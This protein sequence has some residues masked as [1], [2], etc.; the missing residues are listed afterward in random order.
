[1]SPVLALEKTTHKSTIQE[2][3][4]VELIKQIRLSDTF[5][6][7]CGWSDELLVENIVISLEKKALNSPNLNLDPLYQLI[8]KAFY[9]AIAYHI[10][11][12]TGHNT[13]THIHV[14]N[15]EFSSAVICC[16]SVLVLNS[17]IS[18]YK[19]LGFFSLPELIETAENT[20]REAVIKASYYLDF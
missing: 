3:F 15:K 1:M 7:Y 4:L 11:Q 10:E 9:Q 13:E 5:S 2:P 12:T 8:I 20:I 6:K 16:G 19:S 17:L 14:R 18:G